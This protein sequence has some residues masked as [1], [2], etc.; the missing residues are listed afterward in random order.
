MTAANATQTSVPA[1]GK[2][3]A[4]LGDRALNRVRRIAKFARRMSANAMNGGVPE[5]HPVFIM[6]CQRSGTR[7]PLSVL[8]Q[9]PAVLTYGEGAPLYYNG[10]MLRPDDLLEQRFAR[11]VFPWLVLKPLCESHRARQL[12]ERFPTSRIIWIFRGYAETVKSTSLK[13]SSGTTVVKQMVE[14]RLRPDDWRRGGLTEESLDV[15]KRLYRPELTLDHA[16]ALLWYLRNRLVLDQGLFDCERVLVV[17]YEDLTRDP[18]Q[19]FA[20]VFEFIGEPLHANYTSDVRDTRSRMT[21]ALSIP[22]PVVQTCKALFEEIDL[23]Y[24]ASLERR[25]TR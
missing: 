11:C 24:H 12:L 21:P 14:G 17:K 22:E 3:K 18:I 19:H 20:R 13:W 23:R 8:E 1:R 2:Q 25:R 6:G 9:A 5:T 10:L 7:V 4:A 16:N 15:V